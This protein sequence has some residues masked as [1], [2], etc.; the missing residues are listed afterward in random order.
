MFA[1]RSWARAF[2]NLLE[3]S[4]ADLTDGLAALE[5]LASWAGSLPGA[6]F[7]SAAAEKLEVLIRQGIKAAPADA[8]FDSRA[9]DTAV[10]FLLFAVKKNYFCH[11]ALIIKDVKKMLDEK[12]GLVRACLEYALPPE[13][14]LVERLQQAIKERSGAVR[15]DLTERQR[16]ELIGGYRLLIGYELIDASIRSQLS[17]LEQRLS[18][19]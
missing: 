9:I 3:Q 10:S 15:V 13:E 6:V 7:G 11:I 14:G 17:R 19:S 1:Y 5:A 16:P 2:V 18:N 4:D 8:G 12:Q